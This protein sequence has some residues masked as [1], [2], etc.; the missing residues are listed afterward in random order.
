MEC[1]D[2]AE[3]KK[4]NILLFLPAS[5]HLAIHLPFP[6]NGF[7]FCKC[8]FNDLIHQFYDL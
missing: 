8:P 7:L 1:K 2:V 5:S 6:P 3:T 4:E